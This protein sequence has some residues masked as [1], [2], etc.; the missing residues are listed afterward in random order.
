MVSH[1][2]GLRKAYAGKMEA[3]ADAEGEEEV[4]GGEW[5]AGDEGSLWLLGQ[6][7]GLVEAIS[8]G[9]GTTFA[10]GLRAKL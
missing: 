5:M 9:A 2:F 1:I 3:R 8:G 7:D 10:P 6:V 4:E